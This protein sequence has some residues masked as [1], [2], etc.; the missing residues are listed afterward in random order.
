[1]S[2]LQGGTYFIPSLPSVY[3]FS[4]GRP[5]M[6]DSA[7]LDRK[8]MSRILRRMHSPEVQKLFEFKSCFFFLVSFSQTEHFFADLRLEDG[9]S[10]I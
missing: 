3:T 2:T 10:S 1:M 7:R 4:R 5:L 8:S 6:F 9:L